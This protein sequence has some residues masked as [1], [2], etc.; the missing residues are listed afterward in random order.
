ME[1]F[2]ADLHLAHKNIIDLCNR[3]FKNCGDMDKTLINN[4]NSVVK[5]HR[6]IVYLLGDF[7]LRGKNYEQWIINTL[8]K[9]KG[10]KILILGNHDRLSPFEYVDLG[11]ESVHTSMIIHDHIVLTH[12]PA[13]AV[14]APKN[15]ITLCGHIHDAFKYLMTPRWIVNV[16][17]DVWDYKPVS[18][19]QI[20][21]YTSIRNPDTIKDG[22]RCEFLQE[23]RE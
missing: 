8:R 7:S 21:E 13:I 15:F 4:W 10:R 5:S 6:D 3:P 22:H 1:Y 14:A 16:G 19:N 12:D 23:M 17:V 18:L 11:F 9:L 20:F 2:T